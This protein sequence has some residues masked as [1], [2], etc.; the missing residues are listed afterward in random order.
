MRS[1][2][3]RRMIVIAV[4][5]V[6]CHAAIAMAGSDGTCSCEGIG[7]ETQWTIEDTVAVA[8]ASDWTISLDG[9][10]IAW[11][12]SA[13]EAV[14]D[15]EKRVNSLWIT[16]FRDMGSARLTHDRDTA[17]KP[18]FSP[19]GR[20]LAFL[21]TRP[22]PARESYTC[23][24]K[25]KDGTRQV[26]MLSLEGGEPVPLT[27]WERDII[28]F[29]WIDDDTI[30]I[31]APR[32]LT[33]RDR[34]LRQRSDRTYV[35]DDIADEPQ[36]R[37]YRISISERI[38][39][40]L[41]DNEDWIDTLA[42]SPDGR[43]AVVRAQQSLSFTFD[44]VDPPHTFL[45]DIKAEK[46]SRLFADGFEGRTI[47]PHT[48][49]WSPDSRVIYFMDEY[50]THPRYRMATITRL[51]AY[52]LESDRLEL[53][54]LEGSRGFVERKYLPLPDG[55]IALV[56][57]GVHVSPVR[58]THVRGNWVY[59]ELTGQYCD[60]LND[61]GAVS[62]DGRRV[63][64]LRSSSTVPEQWYLAT[65]KG[66]SLLNDRQITRLNPSFKDKPTGRVDIITWTGARDE[67]VEGLLFYPLDW[68]EGERRPLLLDIHGGPAMA[69]RDI[70]TIERTWR[71]PLM[72][73]RQ[74]GAFVLR[75]NY[76]GSR[77][78]GF[79][80]VDSLRGNYYELERIDIE[81]GVDS[82]IEKGLVDPDRLGI[83][84]WSNGGILAIDIITRTS[85]Y[86]AASIGAADVEWISDYG[87]VDFGAAFDTYYLGYAPWENPSL[88]VDK[89]PLFRLGNVT[90]PTII[91][92]GDKDRAVPHSQS[93]SLYRALQQIGKVP[94]RFLVFPDEEHTLEQFAHQ[95]RKML[96]DIAWFDRYLFDRDESPHIL[97]KSNSPLER[98]ILRARAAQVD[99]RYGILVGDHL[100]PETVLLGTL[101]ITRFEVTNAQFAAF[102]GE[103][104]FPVGD[105]NKP[106]CGIQP[107]RVLEY[108]TWL[109]RLTGQIWRM[110]TVVEARCL[111]E[112]AGAGGNVLDYWT[113]FAPGSGDVRKIEHM[114]AGQTPRISLLMD[115]GSF[116]GTGSNPVFDLNGNAAEWAI[117]EQ[118]NVVPIGPS[119]I[120]PADELGFNPPPITY[121]GIRLIKE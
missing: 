18:L 9:T 120:R 39:R 90:T 83:C 45:F 116:P 72:M 99:H 118:E 108:V 69:D 111:A 30:M 88:Y 68:K 22:L 97:S 62:H 71:S 67:Q 106:V 51:F 59:R 33:V 77:G 27:S 20:K 113:G 119:A 84:G 100:I 64:Y 110:P 54:P 49:R 6:F 44:E 121:C 70:W 95:R 79:E 11:I 73:F 41:T 34:V 42:V 53:L 82:L 35:V 10:A 1:T 50:S 101:N 4:T 61:L 32:V 105:D 47:I 81:K 87:N 114:L 104:A 2:M 57:K 86:K 66:V 28:D 78:Y 85:R 94:V 115:V 60:Q 75:P 52:H 8:S 98:S 24:E 112:H 89:S 43:Y 91:F 117:D 55:V 40:K 46:L 23:D 80:W 17:S 16:R 63:I 25:P 107:K 15:D 74:R 76:H 12:Y 5:M 7:M 3:K 93:W 103:H 31:V 56:E 14:E 109:S 96:E 102:D 21:S 29:S 13:V 26:W 65:L 48:I 19:D 92:S 58:F 36:I 37:L 38:I